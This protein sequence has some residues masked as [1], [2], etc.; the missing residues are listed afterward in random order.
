VNITDILT[1]HAA[2]RPDHP[3]IEDRGRVVTYAELDRQVDAAAANLQAAGLVSGDLVG[4]MLPDSAEHLTLLLA[5][6]RLGAV[7]V[8][9]DG[10]LPPP[11]RRQAA[12]AAGVRAI[13]TTRGAAPVGDIPMLTLDAICRPS[14]EPFARPSLGL[15]H[16]LMIVQSSGT[17]GRPKSFVWSHARM[18]VQAPRHQRC[19]GLTWQDRYLAVVKMSF[20]WEREICLV[21]LCLGA[22]IVVNRARTLAELVQHI[23]GG[24]ITAL[25]LTPAHLTLLLDH[26]AARAPLLPG[27]RAMVVGSAPLTHER[28][29][30][31]RRKL[32][33]NFYEQLGANEAGLLILGSPADQDARPAAIGRVA[34]G[35]EAR[36]V[37]EDGRP[38][39]PGEVGL[40][41]FRGE[42]FPAAYLDDAEATTRAF[43]DGWFYPGDLA[44][45]DSDGF[46][47]FKG[48][49]D[50]VIN[51][52]GAKFYPV[53]V[54][55]LLL[56]HPSVAEVAV[57]GWPDPE[58]G[59]VAVAYIVARRNFDAEALSAWCR[60]RVAGYKVPRW[61]VTVDQ[62]P[63][64]P[65]GKILKRRLKE[66]FRAAR[67]QAEGAA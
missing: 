1:E 22:T 48:R 32:T 25:A 35:V 5:L 26:P 31:V 14:S 24:G 12:E 19:L 61:Y 63:R 38:L 20:F 56:A 60:E 41:G 62:L 54:E 33:P 11:E 28:R 6:A 17:T 67:L 15:D 16:P 53:E 40:V 36:I 44:A 57:F 27:I 64:N 30:L 49:A 59:E 13:I 66:A 29:L 21:M 43:R 52:E 2:R 39:P 3:A 34:D 58:H 23:N 47:H 10:F 51:N 45:I 7:M 46:F 50:D 18:A 4:V 55:K 8:A 9:I 37:G 65:A 42:G